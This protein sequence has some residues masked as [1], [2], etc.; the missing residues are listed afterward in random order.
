MNDTVNIDSL[1]DAT[2]DDLEDLPSFE[3]YPAGIHKV[4]ISMEL[5]DIN[6]HPSVDVSCKLVETMELAEPTKDEVPV[7][8][9]AAGTL[10]MMDNEYG[11]GNFKLIATP[12][13]AALGLSSPREVIEACIDI[14]CMIVTTIKLDKN[15]KTIRRMNIKELEVV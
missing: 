9:S 2:L 1:L 10:C 14:E 6:G 7:A 13:G 8:G 5:K 3:P 12:I 15:D 4:L 11:R